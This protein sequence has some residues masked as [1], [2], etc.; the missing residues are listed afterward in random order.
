[1]EASGWRP[2]ESVSD[3]RSTLH[4]DLFGLNGLLTEE[5]REVRERVR[6]FSDAEVI[7]IIADCWERGEFPFQL[8]PKLAALGIGGDTVKGYGCAGLSAV[9]AGL[10]A[11]ELARGDGS[12]YTFFGATSGFAINTIANLGSE[13]QKKKWI[14][15]MARLEKLGAFA[16]T[17]P[18]HGSDAVML[19]TKARRK[20][21]E[22]VIDGKKR[23]IGNGTVADV[24]IIWARDENDDLGGFLVEEGSHGL[25]ATRITG[26]ASKRP[27]IQADLSLEGV[28]VPV[29][30]RLP[31]A[32]TFKDTTS[33]LAV[34]RCGVA[35]E[36]LGHAI[37][38]YETAL[39][40]TRE[41]KQFGKPIASFQL[42]QDKLAKMLA[43]IT[44][45]FLLCIQLGRRAEAGKMTDV[46]ASLAKMNNA[47]KARR[48]CLDARDIMGG[49]GILYEYHVAR[50]WADMEAVYT[51]EGTD[52]INSLIVGREITGYSAFS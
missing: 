47:Q 45:M 6:T 33:A 13:E 43:D 50:H 21:D 8:V 41:R 12:I 31:G 24:I 40:Y 2:G 28:R 27:G 25:Q 1:M 4:P 7:P 22:Y 3:A 16:L 19:E 11:M 34:V 29:E 9:G 26:K 37:A 5:E 42:V 36:A 23:W 51:Y 39:A 18:E 15:C 32:R 49:N 44:T 35:W 46:A 14:P 48:I 17:E 52:S 30:N 20:G 38:V 10:A